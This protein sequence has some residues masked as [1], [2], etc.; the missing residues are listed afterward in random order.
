VL[1][2]IGNYVEAR[3]IN[4]GFVST[5]PVERLRVFVGTRDEALR[6]AMED[7][8]QYE[9]DN[10]LAWRGDPSLRTTMEFEVKFKD[11]ET[12]WKP[13]DLDLAS[14]QPFED[15]CRRNRELYLLLYTTDHVSKAASAIS[16]RAITD[17]QPGDTIFVDLR[18]F[19]TF[20]YDNL[21]ALPDKYH[22]KYVVRVLFTRWTGRTHKKLD[23]QI[24]VFCQTFEFNNLFVFY[25]GHQREVGDGMVEVTDDFLT[26]YPII[27][28]MVA[29]E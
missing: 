29:R 21:L 11:G 15:F 8:N 28:T 20:V 9:V 10:I 12:V 24:P 22:I 17:V 5:F 14:C 6:M 2:H 16:S 23:A 4:V 18:Y 7:L 19:G 3:H 27:R 1:R 13:W 26:E 25:Y